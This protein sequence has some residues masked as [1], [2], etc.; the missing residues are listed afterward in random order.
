MVV[1]DS[2]L[3]GLIEQLSICP[4]D[5]YDQFSIKVKLGKDYFEANTTAE[6]KNIVYGLHPNPKNLFSE[7]KKITQ[8][9]ILPPGKQIIASSE[10]IYNIPKDHFGLIQTKG[11]LARLFVQTTCN[12]GQIEPGFKGYITLEIVNLS[13]WTIELPVGSEVAQLYLFK[14]S[15]PASRPYSGRYKDLATEGPTLPIF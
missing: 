15:S 7:K 11:T 10:A 6:M 4:S 14:C 9:L 2:N 1:I 3:K 5:L 8:N 12:D 13:P